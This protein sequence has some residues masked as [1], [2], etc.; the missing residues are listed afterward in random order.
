MTQEEKQQLEQ[1]TNAPSDTEQDALELLRKQKE[2]SVS[3]EDYDKL[4]ADN[5]RLME[6]FLNGDNQG[7]AKEEPKMR[8]AKEV[9]DEM[10]NGKEKTNLRFIELACE[11]RDAY[12]KETGIDCF[13]GASHDIT[14]TQEDYDMAE[15]SYKV[16]KEC[17][18]K[19]NGD[20]QRFTA[21]LQL[22]MKDV[23]IPRFNY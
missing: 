18:E 1:G 12:K 16:Y 13:V 5:K 19:A 15:N 20:P 11:Y 22:R 3:R 9:Y 4:R 17:I 6:N 2:N 14:P 21:E 10:Y 23:N 7:Q 8:T